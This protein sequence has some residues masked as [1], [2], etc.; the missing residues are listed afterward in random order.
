M[1]LGLAIA[2]LFA[3]IALP[4]PV[5][6]LILG[7]LSLLAIILGGLLGNYD[8]GSPSDVGVGELHTNTVDPVSGQAKG[9]DVL[10]VQGTWVYDPLHEGWN[11]IHPVKVCTKM[12]VSDGDW[13]TPPD[14]ILRLR[15]GFQVAQAVT[16]R[17]R[18]ISGTFT[19]TSMGASAT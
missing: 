17:D 16:R 3:C 13:S 5:V 8:F 2:A 18:N 19:L 6:G 4:F 1:A 11:E 10:Y 7:L 15:K 12:P 9:A 14:M